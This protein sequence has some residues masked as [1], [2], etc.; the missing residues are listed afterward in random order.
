[1]ESR[2]LPH[3]RKRALRPLWEC[4][5][6]QTRPPDKRYILTIRLPRL[7]ATLPPSYLRRNLPHRLCAQHLRH[8]AYAALPRP[9]AGERVQKDACGGGR[10][11]RQADAQLP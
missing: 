5:R 4:I 3:L 2:L 7:L 11:P 6:R 8:R 10:H 9:D 1:M